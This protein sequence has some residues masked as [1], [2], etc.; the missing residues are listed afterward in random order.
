M[1]DTVFFVWGRFAD[2]DFV[3][4]LNFAVLIIWSG[5]SML[6]LPLFQWFMRRRTVAAA[7]AE[8]R[9]VLANEKGRVKN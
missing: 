8:A 6:T 9:P 5:I 1:G 7:R 4:G 3:V 2:V